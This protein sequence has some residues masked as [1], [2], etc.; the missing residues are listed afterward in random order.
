MKRFSLISLVCLLSM[1][2]PLFADTSVLLDFSTLTP[3]T[4][5]DENEATI[6][7]FS[8]QAGTG[9]SDEERDAMKTSLSIENWEVNL[10]SSSRTVDNMR[11]SMT[12]AVLVNDGAAKYGG[13]MVMG[14]RVY[15]PNE[16]FN[17]YAI[18]RPPFEIPAYMRRTVLQGDGTLIEDDADLRGSKFDG[19]GVV[20]NVGILKS[21]SV[22][23]YGSNYPN[24]FAL[25]F[26]DQNNKEQ[27]IFMS[28]L[29]FDGWR[30][31]TWSN[32]NYINEV[33]NRE[34]KSYPLYPQAEPMRKLVGLVFYKDSTQEGGD[35]IAYIK[36][37]SITYDR[38]MVEVQRDINEEEIWGILNER[39]QARR[40]AEFSKLGTMQVMRY[41]ESKKMHTEDS[42]QQ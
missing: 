14:I 27:Q 31:L 26:K 2:V 28:Y 11:R 21:V 25:I 23:V 32:P 7:D 9:F 30:E 41:L 40:T 29:E 6:V 22:N 5:F 3:D 10:A 16:P 18:V 17:S 4:E 33:R 42:E 12:K 38:A 36:D 39:E 35:F 37:I 24:G 1:S 13:E 19:Y 20:K 8:E 34:I 15:F